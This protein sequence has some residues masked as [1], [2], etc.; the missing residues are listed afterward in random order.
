MTGIDHHAAPVRR[1][2]RLMGT[3]VSVDVRGCIDRSMAAAALDE[4]LAWLHRIEATFSVFRP[5]SQISRIGRGEL[6]PDDAAPDVREVLVRCDE[7]RA[8]TEGAFDHRP[9]GRPDRP[10]DPN[11]LVKGWSIDRVALLLQLRGVR[12]Y[13]INAG[14]DVR[15]GLP[16]AG[17]SAWRVGVRH[18]DDPRSVAAVLEVADAAVATSARYERGAHVWGESG[19]LRSVTVVGPELGT[20]DALATAILA[21]GV[22]TPQWLVRFPG[23]EPVVITADRVRWSDRLPAHL[24]LVDLAANTPAS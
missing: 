4:A 7:L 11:A 13:C 1:V 18:P 10:L 20:A 6:H 16:P 21:S 8:L 9:P 23:Y 3:V 17:S 24:R 5:T 2:E 12:S 22:E 19:P 14:G 15:C